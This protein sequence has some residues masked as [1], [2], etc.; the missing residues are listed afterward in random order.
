M[1]TTVGIVFV[2]GEMFM[3]T[4]SVQ[5]LLCDNLKYK[6]ASKGKCA[7]LFINSNKNAN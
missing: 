3:S 6:R 4:L 7:V 1:V 2:F 5:C